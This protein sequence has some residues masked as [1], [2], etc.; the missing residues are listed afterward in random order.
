M[1]SRKRSIFQGSAKQ[2]LIPSAPTRMGKEASWIKRRLAKFNKVPKSLFGANLLES[3][4]RFNHRSDIVKEVRK[5]ARFRIWQERKS[6][7]SHSYLLQSCLRYTLFSFQ[8]RIIKSQLLS[9]KTFLL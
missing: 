9:V 6:L 1:A 2:V 5:L 4:W 7:S 8:L 3:E